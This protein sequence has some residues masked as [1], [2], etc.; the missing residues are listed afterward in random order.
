[1]SIQLYDLTGAEDDRQFSPYCW[2]IKMALKHKGMDYET[3]PWR[4]TEKD[5]IGFTDQ[6]RVP[7]IVNKADNDKAVWDSWD[8]ARYLDEQSPDP[9][10]IP[11]GSEPGILFVKCWAESVVQPGLIPIILM[12]VYDHLH[13]KD[14]DY[15]RTTRE[16]ALGTT[17]EDFVKD[18]DASIAAFRKSLQPLRILLGQQDFAGGA[19]PTMADYIVFGGFAWARAVSEHKLLKE[20]DPVYAWRERMLD[21]NNGYARS[22]KGYAV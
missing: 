6:P 22:A 8:I 21:L 16:K 18:T 14:K 2:R 19:S 7:V 15:F 5:A 4:F 13:A 3:I 12:D 17:L 1:M 11:E 20:D 9:A 10:L